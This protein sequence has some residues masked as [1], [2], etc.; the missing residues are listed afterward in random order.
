LEASE[1]NIPFV[2][3]GLKYSNADL[4]SDFQEIQFD[5]NESVLYLP[6]IDQRIAFRALVKKYSENVYLIFLDTDVPENS[7]VNKEILKNIYDSEMETFLKQQMILGL[8]GNMV[9]QKLF[10]SPSV[11]HLNEG[12]TAF[13]A[14]GL[15]LEEACTK[16]ISLKEA[17]TLITSKIVATKHTILSAAG[18]NLDK[19]LFGFYLGKYC[20]ENGFSVDEVF[21]FEQGSK[22]DDNIFSTTKFLIKVAGRQNGVSRLHT[23]CEKKA[24]PESDLIAITNGVNKNRWIAKEWGI[25]NKNS[26]KETK[27]ILR[28]RL[29]E[30][31]KKETGTTISETA[32]TFVWARRFAKYKRPDLL[33]SEP[34]KLLKLLSDN[35]YPIQI[36][37]SGKAHPADEYGQNTLGMIQDFIEKN[38]LKSKIVYL[39]NYCP[40]I[41]H[42]LTA[43][44]DV[45]LNT[46]ERG[47]EACGTSGMK[48]GLNGTLQCSVSDGWIDEINL[49]EIGWTLPD[50]DTKT[51][52]D[53]LF[54]LL[55]KE[56][57][58]EF[59]ADLGNEFAFGS[60]EDKMRKTQEIILKNYTTT[61]MLDDY[62]T[63][64]YLVD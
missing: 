55:E 52:A 3:L 7:A 56:I 19:N 17:F 60:W 54:D 37:L 15:L 50:A 53:A 58:P 39:P 13:A 36:V 22:N 34:E 11:Y 64:L 5:N 6:I 40:K 48:A 43:G 63:K 32:L 18:V 25:S 24:H 20:L 46:P 4:S 31:I 42:Y 21:D 62:F 26:F 45:W 57:I 8:G 38:N 44:A 41:S 33:F 16:Q 2:A 23:V 27:N 59:Y 47:M 9:L 12:H 29:V 14:L 1:Q 30:Y 49:N 61:R 35:K 51:T 28:K 10:I